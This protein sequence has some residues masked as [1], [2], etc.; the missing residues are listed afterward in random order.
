MEFGTGYILPMDRDYGEAHVD[1]TGTN[2]VGIAPIRDVGFSVPFGIAAAN[3][4]G[5]AAKIRTGTRIIELQFP[6]AGRAQRNAQT[7]E[8]YGKVQRQALEELSRANNVDFT[9]HASFSV[10]GLA[11]MDQQGNFSKQNKKFAIDEIRRAIDFAG[12]VARGGNITVHTG[13]FQRPISEQPWAKDPA[14]GKIMFRNYAEEPERAQFR[15]VD[16]RTGQIV[17]QARKNQ[18]IARP[19]WLAAKAGETYYDEEGNERTAEEGEK[20][21]IDYE[22][23]RVSE[24]VNRVPEYDQDKRRYKV[25]YKIW[26]D[27]KKEAHE[28]TEEARR[29]W[30]E[31]NKSEEARRRFLDTYNQ[32]KDAKSEDQ[33]QFYPEEAYVRATL[34]TN[35][36]NAK[37]WARYYGADVDEETEELERLKKARELYRKIEEGVPEEEKWKILQAVPASV[38]DLVPPTYKKPTEIIDRQISA[39]KKHLDYSKETSLS[40]EQ[41][42]SD[43]Y[44]LMNHIMADRRYALKEAYDSYA[45]AGLHA[46]EKTRQVAK[47]QAEGKIGGREIRPL[48]VAM[49]N[50]FPESY[51]GHPDEIIDLV[52]GAR[53]SMVE[54]LRQRGYNDEQA[55]KAAEDHVKGHLDTGHLN[56]WRK[57]WSYDEKSSPEENDR[58]FNA[59][60]L[61]KVEEM[62]KQNIIGSVHL[63]D[64]FGYQDEHLAPGQGNTPVTEM[65]KILKQHGYKGPLVV[66]PGADATTDLSDFHGLMKTWRL[67]GSPVYGLGAGLRG[68]SRQRAWGDVQ[69]G[70][71]GQTQPPYFVFGAYSPSEDW[72]LWSGVPME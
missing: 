43:A 39:I 33:I 42:A 19:I 13:E 55:R 4:Q 54:K 1:D 46:W 29:M 10:M 72:T 5:V 27:F 16:E 64:N 70:Y 2:D 23:K 3:V 49:E 30:R 61:K 40:Q 28:R 6:G 38:R 35:A 34:E 48:F 14:T 60:M 62:A 45:E 69:Y 25:E 21:Y 47:Q 36:A 52:T 68:P 18:R 32:F 59:W 63:T 12:D 7:P 53:R 24:L 15:V 50:I 20:V 41:Q 71:F 51:G 66:E 26:D 58:K 44:E 56:M 8:V 17:A 31:R 57:Y 65:I 9:T 67:F 37:G 22:R 11:G